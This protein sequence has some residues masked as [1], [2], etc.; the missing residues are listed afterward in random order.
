VFESAAGSSLGSWPAAPSVCV[1]AMLPN[2]GVTVGL[3][4]EL[5][6]FNN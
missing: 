1:L 5:D 4:I 6:P 3:L 2:G